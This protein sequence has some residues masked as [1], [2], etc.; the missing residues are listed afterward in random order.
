MTQFLNMAHRL[1][2]LKKNVQR[3][4]TKDLKIGRTGLKATLRD[5]PNKF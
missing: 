5:P 3:P 2:N 1:L 4:K